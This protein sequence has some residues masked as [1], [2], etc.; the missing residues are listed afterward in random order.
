MQFINK[1]LLFVAGIFLF[2]ACSGKEEKRPTSVLTEE[3]MIALVIDIQLADATVTLSN[4]GQSNLPIDKE[5]LFAAIYKKHNTSKK[6][7]EESF[8][9]YSGHPEQFEKIY[10]E[11][12]TGLSKKQAELAK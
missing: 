8:F 2:I 5:K 1:S 11:V 12:I 10:E 3:K 7:V 9:Y 4:Y 6:I